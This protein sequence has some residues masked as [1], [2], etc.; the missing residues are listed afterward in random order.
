LLQILVVLGVVAAVAAVAAGVLRGGASDEI[1]LPEATTSVPALRL[2]PDR[3]GEHDLENLRFS[4]GFRGYRMDEV[5]QVL[6]RMAGEL[7]ARDTEVAELRERLE[8]PQQT[9]VDESVAPGPGARQ[10]DDDEGVEVAPR[11]GGVTQDVEES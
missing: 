5:D 3:L 4:I 11:L 7:R 8:G 10:P 6:D 2:P 9:E 1:G